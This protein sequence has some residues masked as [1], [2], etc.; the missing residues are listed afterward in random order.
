L[1]FVSKAGAGQQLED[2]EDAYGDEPQPDASQAQ[3]TKSA[4]LTSTGEGQDGSWLEGDDI[5]DF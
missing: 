1:R 4:A 3:G 2:D 5:E